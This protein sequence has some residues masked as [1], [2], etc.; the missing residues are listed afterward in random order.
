MRAAARAPRA[1]PAGVDAGAG[2]GARRPRV[3]D[4]RAGAC[5]AGRGLS[6]WCC[7]RTTGGAPNPDVWRPFFVP[8]PDL[9]RRGRGR[10][11]AAVADWGHRA[12]PMCDSRRETRADAGGEARLTWEQLRE[13]ATVWRGCG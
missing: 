4:V 6:G 10:I 9:R 7:A 11:V 8:P 3:G 12:T 1:A 2:A 13:H 5:A